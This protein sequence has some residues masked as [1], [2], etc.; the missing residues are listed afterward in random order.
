MFD[1]KVGQILVDRSILTAEQLGQAI[2][3]SV[4]AQMVLSHYLVD[5]KLAR[6]VDIAAALAQILE[7]PFIEKIT[8]DMIDQV[9]ISRI[10]FKFLRQHVILPI[11]FDGNQVL[12][13]ADP[14]NLQALDDIALL[15]PGTVEHA[16]GP[17]QI[18]LDAINKYYPFDTGK[19][20]IAD[21]KE[22]EEEE[23]DLEA[24]GDKDIVDMASEAPIVK[25]VNHFIFQG[26]K[27]DAS[28]IHIEPFEKELSVRY[29]IDGVMH[30]V[31]L[32]PKR[33]HGA[34]V[35][36][37]KIMSN[38][39][40]AEKRVPQ[41]GR[42]QV[43][44]AEKAIDLRVSVLPCNFGERVVMRI[45]DKSK[46]AVDL[47]SLEMSPGDY[48]RVA[49]SISRPHG[50]ILVSGPTGS[51]K[52]T[53]LYSILKRLNSEDRNIITV[54]DP[55]EYTISG[56]SQVQV[57]EKAG[58][59]FAGA[60]RS[61]LRQDPDMVLIGEIRDGETAEIAT[62]AA[63]TGHL[64]MS[65]IHTNSAPA[66]ITRLIDMGVEPF[67]VSSSLTCVIAQRLVR[68]LCQECRQSYQPEESALR[69][70]GLTASNA[71]GITFYQAVGCQNCL[72]T[73]YKG[74]MAIFEVM[75]IDDKLAS[76]I[77]QRSDASII[78]AYAIEKGMTELS[79]DGLR[80]IK[81]GKTT[82]EEVLA[83]SY[84]S[85]PLDE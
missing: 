17:H 41:D 20:M 23:F 66:T 32:P 33:Y 52:T 46:G 53:T 28:D 68:R 62:Q 15:I 8:E 2:T 29:R 16:V 65:T 57:N 76:L 49:D 59:T 73:G 24:I 4:S 44:V 35:S 10:A 14:R 64:V 56:I 74:R 61:I 37:I 60:L 83:V 31:L 85:N 55:V 5:K 39:N 1:K 79:A 82:I 63:L 48:K 34:I 12:L 77:V 72:N 22:D 7:I 3:E 58:L 47:E 25:M 26:V 11:V 84:A 9:M 75:T 36:R 80:G 54:E 43:R 18:I 69:K 67:L 51:G 50:I 13:S 27:D 81:D 38:L 42:I 19:E 40:I 78:R 6:P 21:L 70:L 71:Q 45:L 30:Q